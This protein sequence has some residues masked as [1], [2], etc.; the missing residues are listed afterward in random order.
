MQ[1]WVTIAALTVTLV[2]LPAIPREATGSGVARSQGRVYNLRPFFGGGAAPRT[3]GDLSLNSA[4]LRSLEAAVRAQVNDY[5]ASQGLPPLAANA[6][7]DAVARE[8]S[9]AMAA[10][11]VQFSHDGFEQRAATLRRS[12]PYRSV[13]ENLAFNRGSA[14]PVAVAV[15]GWL[16]SPG[17]QRNIVG[18][19]NVT[20]VGVARARDGSYYFTQL[21][22][23]Q[24]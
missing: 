1:R 16:E 15:R 7:M 3:P 9:E 21:F 4:S 23:Q 18:D 17:H 19:F 20:G 8:H 13:A 24:R 22:L 6:R 10:G 2:G 5:R 11:R 14:E 12:L